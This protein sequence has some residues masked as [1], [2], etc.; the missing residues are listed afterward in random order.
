M[1]DVVS[2]EQVSAVQPQPRRMRVRRFSVVQTANVAAVLYLVLF[3]IFLVPAGLI[4]GLAGGVLGNNVS[5]IFLIFVPILYAVFGW[6]V[7]A[8]ACLLYN[9]V[10]GWIGG[11]E[12]TLEDAPA[13]AR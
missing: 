7:V 11:V 8:L 12:F 10:A 5:G 2:T 6:I 3:G 13:P 9:L 1:A 4:S